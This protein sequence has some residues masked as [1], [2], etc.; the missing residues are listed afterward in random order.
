MDKVDK[1]VVQHIVGLFEKSGK[2]PIRGT[3][4]TGIHG[5]CA[6]GVFSDDLLFCAE[7]A[8]R[9]IREKVIENEDFA[10]DYRTGVIRGFD[11]KAPGFDNKYHKR[12]YAV[13]KEVWEKVKT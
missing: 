13:G 9:Y 4:H 6:I 5:C 10:L 12:G 3:F 1:E 8:E 2:Q 7:T 11:G